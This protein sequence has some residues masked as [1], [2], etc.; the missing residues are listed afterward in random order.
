MLRSNA[1]CKKHPAYNESENKQ[2]PRGYTQADGPSKFLTI[3]L[4]KHGADILFKSSHRAFRPSRHES[5]SSTTIRSAN[6]VI[7]RIVVRKNI[8]ERRFSLEF[9][10]ERA[11]FHP[12]AGQTRAA[13]NCDRRGW[14]RDCE[15]NSVSR[16]IKPLIRRGSGNGIRKRAIQENRSAPCKRQQQYLSFSS[17]F[18][19]SLLRIRMRRAIKLD[20]SATLPIRWRRRSSSPEEKSSDFM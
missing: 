14:P 19:C 6:G 1:R 15:G 5:H 16:I 2:F 13:I 7:E 20:W 17:R 18:C 8:W 4:A 10:W 9:S 3:L 12:V 11:T